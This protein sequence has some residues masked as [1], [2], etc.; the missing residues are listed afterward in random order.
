MKALPRVVDRLCGHGWDA[1][2]GLPA[3]LVLL[4][5]RKAEILDVRLDHGRVVAVS[6]DDLRGI[7]FR[8]AAV[9]AR[10]S[11]DQMEL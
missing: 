4:C 5:I 3:V 2:Q 7:F 6:R 9:P 1:H 10:T 8:F 11:T